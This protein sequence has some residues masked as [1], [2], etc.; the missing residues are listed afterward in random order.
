M[1]TNASVPARTSSDGARIVGDRV[2]ITGVSR[3]I[4][5]AIAMAFAGCGARIVGIHNEAAETGHRVQRELEAA[6]AEA[7]LV[8]GDTGRSADVEALAD[9]AVAAFGGIDVW[10]NN[11]ARLFV[12]PFVEMSDEDW[13]GLMAANLHGYFYGSRAAARRIEGPG[14]II[15]VTSAVNVLA[16]A[17]LGAYTSA[18]GAIAGMTRTLALELAPRGVTVN[19]IAPGAIETPLNAAAYT[20]EVRAVYHER[21]PAGR[22]GD[23]ED[24]AEVALFLASHGAGYVTGQEL[25]VDG[26]LTINGTVGHGHS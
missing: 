5:L 20:D 1:P 14:R 9:R 19:A 22:I 13:H 7:L 23:A 11:A 16:V 3:G 15:N 10:V 8:E 6:G 18:K 4:G 17:D 2:V 25:L 21:I 12:R 26:G 24:V